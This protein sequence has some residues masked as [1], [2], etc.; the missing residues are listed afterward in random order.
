M[1]ADLAGTLQ[2]NTVLE[3]ELGMLQK[4]FVK[5]T[6]LLYASTFDE[7]HTGTNFISM[8]LLVTMAMAAISQQIDFA[9]PPVKHVS[10]RCG[11]NAAKKKSI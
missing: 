6:K 11:L 9:V 10:M 7:F 2:K 1:V 4:C 5:H 3:V 8:L